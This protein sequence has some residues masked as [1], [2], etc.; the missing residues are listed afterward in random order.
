MMTASQTLFK[1]LAI[2]PITNTKQS[3]IVDIMLSIIVNAGK[4]DTL[5]KDLKAY[6][7]EFDETR[8]VQNTS[9]DYI[10]ST[11]GSILPMNLLMYTPNAMRLYLLLSVDIELCSTYRVC[12]FNKTIVENLLSPES[13]VSRQA[14]TKKFNNAIVDISNALKLTIFTRNKGDDIQFL[15]IK[16]TPD[17]DTIIKYVKESGFQSPSLL[18]RICRTYN[19]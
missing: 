3:Q 9:I 17:M 6:I 14:N 10:I 13:A 1:E 4:W 11:S 19:N 7:G 16:G 8:L 2:A 15:L 5:K 18:D 12:Q